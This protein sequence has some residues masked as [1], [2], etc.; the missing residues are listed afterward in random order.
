MGR[1]CPVCCE[2]ESPKRRI[3]RDH[4][5]GVY[6]MGNIAL[7]G[8]LVIAPRRHVVRWMDLDRE[9]RDSLERFRALAEKVLLE[10][11]PVRKVYFL[12][13]GEVCPHLH[14]HCFPRTRWMAEDRPEG[15]DI[16]G[17]GLFVRYRSTLACIRTPPEVTA[18]VQRLRKAFSGE[19]EPFA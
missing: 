19:S 18:M 3:A 4:V 15:A 11:E 7:P 8:Y 13:F 9:E 16:D 5:A 6:H 14:T 17:P 12:S 1:D 2:L 10:T